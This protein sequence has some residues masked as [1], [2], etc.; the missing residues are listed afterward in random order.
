MFDQDKQPT[1]IAHFA[2]VMRNMTTRLTYPVQE[3]FRRNRTSGS[4]IVSPTRGMVSSL[5]RALAHFY[6]FW[7]W[8]VV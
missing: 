5:R 7:F 8:V 4:A 2:K 6:R 3:P 1:R